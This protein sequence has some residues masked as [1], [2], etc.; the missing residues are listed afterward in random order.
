MKRITNT[1]TALL[2][3]FLL[4]GCTQTMPNVQIAAT[5]AP[6]YEFTS[7]ICN[8][9]DISVG[10][11]ISENVSCLHDYTLQTKQMRTMENAEVLVISGAGL[12][13]FLLDATGSKTVIDAS[14]SITVLHSEFSHQHETHEHTHEEDPHI[15]LSPEKASQ[16]ATNI[17]SALSDLY[18]QYANQFDQNL[19][20]L[21]KDFAD[22]SAY[23]AEQFQSL[24][25]RQLITFHDGFAYF[26]DAFSLEILF[27]IEEES[28]SEAPA[29]ELIKICQMIEDH[30][31]PAIFTE[32]NGSSSAA[33]IISAQTGAKV[34]QLDLAMS[35]TG[36]FAAMYNNI[37]TIKE[38][39]G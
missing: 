37:N 11:V 22:L 1:I 23:A 13:E 30:A 3:C 28:G 9:T 19:Q 34:Y 6:V 7:R 33:S 39:L 21:L 38:A 17:C 29:S 27:A 32:V 31:L 10:K 35:D 18:P 14:E 16:M 24:K 8:G 2:L 15:W 36:Y 25:T 5:T 12:E 26:A 20:L 4:S